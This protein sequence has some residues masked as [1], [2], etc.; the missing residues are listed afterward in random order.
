MERTN[1]AEWSEEERVAFLEKELTS[2]RPFA[3]PDAELGEEA[4]AVLKS[5]RVLADHLRTW[6]PAGSVRSSSA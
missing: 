6:G 2:A 3:H 1:F 5:Y 4:M